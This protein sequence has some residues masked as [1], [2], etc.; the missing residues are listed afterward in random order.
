MATEFVQF[1][2]SKR[3]SGLI[4]AMFSLGLCVRQRQSDRESRQVFYHIGEYYSAVSEAGPS[5]V[6][7]GDG[8]RA[9]SSLTLTK[10]ELEKCLESL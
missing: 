6:M 10:C 2:N 5:K 9:I 4:F 3:E 1:K 7:L 8:M